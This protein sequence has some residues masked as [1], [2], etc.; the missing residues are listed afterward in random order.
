MA[1]NI[2]W[3]EAS[4]TTRETQILFVG[5]SYGLWSVISTAEAEALLSSDVWSNWPDIEPDE[6]EVACGAFREW[7]SDVAA[8]FPEIA[9]TAR[10]D[11]KPC[12]AGRDN[13]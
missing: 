1:W 7:L 4:G 13:L 11:D 9:G 10:E 6:R 12:T 5:L 8:T 2:Y 3:H